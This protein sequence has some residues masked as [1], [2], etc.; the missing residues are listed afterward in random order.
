MAAPVFTLAQI[1]Q[2]LQRQWGGTGEGTTRTWHDGSIEYA[3]PDVAPNNNGGNEAAGFAPMTAT[4]KAFAREAFELWDDLI[5]SS[6]TETTSA[7]AQITLAY[8]STTTDGGTYATPFL[9]AQPPGSSTFDREFDHGRAWMSTAWTELQNANMAYGERGMETFVHEIGHALGLS[10]PGSYNAGDGSTYATGAEYT[11][12]TQQWTLMSYWAPGADGT[13]IDRVGSAGA[14]DVNADGINAATP[15][16]HDI[17]AIQAKYGADTSTRTGDT[18]YGFNSNAD[19]GA[20]NFALNPN[21]VVAIWDAGGNDTLDC[22]GFSQNQRLDLAAGAFC[23][24]GALTLNVAIAYNVEIENAVGGSGNDTI[25]GNG[26]DNV[27][28][29]GGGD[30]QLRGGTGADVLFGN[31]GDD[32]LTGGSGW[33]DTLLGGAG[34]DSYNVDDLDTIVEG[35]GAGTDTVYSSVRWVLGDNLEN[36][37]LTGTANVNGF[38]NALA[39]QL[40]GNSGNNYLQGFAGADTLRGGDGNDYYELGDVTFIDAQSGSRYDEVIESAN[41]GTDTVSVSYAGNAGYF[42]DANVENVVVVGSTGLR[43]VGNELSNSFVGNA[44]YNLFYGEAGNDTLNGGGGIDD[45]LGGVG[46]DTYVLDDLNRPHQFARYVFDNVGELADEGI[47][48]VLVS[49]LADPDRV[50][51]NSYTLTA[52]VENGAITGTTV[53]NLRGND[54]GNTL[55]GNAAANTL[56]GLAGNDTLSGGAGYDSLLGGAGDDVY[57]LD[58]MNQPNPFALYEFDAVTEAAAEGVDTVLVRSQAAPDRVSTN[59]YTLRGNVENGVI[60]GSVAFNLDGNPL[61]NSL[62]GN[63]AANTLNGLAGDDWLNGGAGYDL[64]RGGAG[65]D[66]YVLDDM[67]LPNPFALYAYDAVAE[68]AGDGIDTVL[69][70]S[71]A[72]PDRVSTNVYTLAPNVDNAVVTGSTVFNLHGNELANTLTGNDAANTLRGFAGADTITGG[73][74]N[75]TLLDV[76]ADLNGDSFSDFAIGDLIDVSGLRFSGIRYDAASGLLELDTAADASFATQLFLGAGLQGEFVAS[77]SAAALPA[78]TAV[79]LMLDSDGDGIGD[80]RDNALNVPN[81]DQR[82]S[83]G[84]G[85]GNVVDADLN[86]D[87]M[88]DLFDLSLLDQRFGSNDADADLNGDGSVDLIDLSIMDGLFGAAPGPSYVDAP[89]QPDTFVASV[90]SAEGLADLVAGDHIAAHYMFPADFGSPLF[91]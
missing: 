8:S 1:A 29:G 68:A 65:D 17:A 52:N 13:V 9:K 42:L 11:Q 48:T 64:L 84:D 44:A 22:S 45:L 19:R 38:G 51:A 2:Q 15:L 18:V 50:S 55:A 21:P 70:R 36:L 31:D 49:P 27:L 72:A 67:N 66:T 73:G 58:D 85:Y 47:D 91:H 86:Q 34:H 78:S 71:Q 24:V 30:D 57:V 37:F 82:D 77:A 12:D 81:P 76:A 41:S 35:A 6:L 56:T 90:E 26:L 28:S 63:A 88:V 40:F 46:N 62:S 79:R 20:F 14:S 10:H 16:L 25:T 32:T 43:V 75:D 60:T 39:N 3:M 7:D 53:F 89:A 87:M 5:Q 74:G 4:Q 61:A 23:D 80:F 59:G 83:D 33:I 54:I 69:V